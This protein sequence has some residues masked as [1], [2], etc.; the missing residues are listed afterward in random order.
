[1]GGVIFLETLRRS[2]RQI[3]YW[4]IGLFIWALYPFLMLP[5]M[6]ALDSYA[7]LVEDLPPALVSAIGM[8]SAAQFATP[9]GFIGYAYFGFLLLILS[10]FGVIAGLNVTANEEE[11]GEMDIL[12]STPVPRWRVIIE[13]LAAYSVMVVGITVIGHAG[14][15]VGKAIAPV[16]FNITDGRL[17]EG[18]LNLIPGTLL[19]IAVTAFLGTL[20][21]RRSTAMAAAGVF[22]V[23][24]YLL[25]LIG[26]AANTDVA[27]VIRQVSLFAHY[28]G[29]NILSTGLVFGSVALLVGVAA[30][31]SG[32]AVRLFQQR[33][34]AV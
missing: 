21:R 25:D 9:E 1:M 22:V 8:S 7:E 11:G 18:S 19:V 4:G 34:I 12:L 32:L 33:D 31:L 29:T 26:R 5:D 2:W 30:L 27:D 14:L 10:V 16:D 13:K 6:E 3:F 28:D 23:A 24:S 15:M 20:L 17:L